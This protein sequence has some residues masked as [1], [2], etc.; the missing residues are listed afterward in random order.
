MGAIQCPRCKKTF[1]TEYDP[2]R[3]R[4]GFFYDSERDEE[5]DQVCEGCHRELTNK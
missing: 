1:Q 4:A 5:Y 2:E 3:F